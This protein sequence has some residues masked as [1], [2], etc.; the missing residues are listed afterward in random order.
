MHL[1]SS[2][3]TIN[4]MCARMRIESLQF[5]RCFF[6][7]A[8]LSVRNPRRRN[9]WAMDSQLFC[10]CDS[11][12]VRLAV[13][14]CAPSQNPV[15]KAILPQPKYSRRKRQ[16]TLFLWSSHWRICK[17]A[18]RIKPNKKID[19]SDGHSLWLSV[20]CRWAM[21][22][23]VNRGSPRCLLTCGYES[24]WTGYQFV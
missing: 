4:C 8:L 5:H 15:F 7:N 24:W 1:K 3:L 14:F 16:K 19:R 21:G 13:L 6:R 22:R 18:S 20:G 12:S 11:S 9:L 17:K 2:C 10:W 23:E